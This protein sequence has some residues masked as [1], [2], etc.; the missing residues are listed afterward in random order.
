MLVVSAILLLATTVGV[1]AL[2]VLVPR[3]ER[4][5]RRMR[6]FGVRHAALTAE[7]ARLG[8]SRAEIVEAS[9]GAGR[10]VVL[11]TEVT[12]FTHASIA[13]IPFTILEQ[14]PATADTSRLVRR[15]HDD[16]SRTVY[17]TISGTARGVSGVLGS[18]WHGRRRRPDGER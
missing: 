14:I 13:A 17:D 10:A 3:R 2:A 18:R 12:R 9:D 4:S 7:R 6:Q 1:V 5:W 8:R 15:I 16:I 11:P